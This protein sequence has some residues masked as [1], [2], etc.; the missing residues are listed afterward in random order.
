MP[1]YENQQYL[2]YDIEGNLCEATQF[3]YRLLAFIGIG[4]TGLVSLLWSFPGLNDF[5]LAIRCKRFWHPRS[6]ERTGFVFAYN[7]C[8][9]FFWPTIK[10]LHT[11]TRRGWRAF[12]I[13]QISIQLGHEFKR[14]SRMRLLT[15]SFVSLYDANAGECARWWQSKVKMVAEMNWKMRTGNS[16]LTSLFNSKSIQS[17][18]AFRTLSNRSTFNV[19]RQTCNQSAKT[20]DAYDYSQLLS[21]KLLQGLYRQEPTSTVKSKTSST[22]EQWLPIRC[23]FF[24]KTHLVFN[25]LEKKVCTELQIWH[26]HHPWSQFASAPIPICWIISRRR[27]VDR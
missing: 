13:I 6:F 25:K 8:K 21:A 23:L 5:G 1:V 17:P 12:S 10:I 16:D 11:W 27:V 22:K 2:E 18:S 20:L 26:Y 24:Y 14:L 4:T 9:I 7:M 19:F 15:V 3:A